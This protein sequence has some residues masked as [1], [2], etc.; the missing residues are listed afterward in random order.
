MLSED[1]EKSS[2]SNNLNGGVANHN[3]NNIQVNYGMF[4]SDRQLN[5]FVRR[6][7]WSP[8]GSF[9]LLPAAIY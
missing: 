9:F 2:F 7:D 6:P 3:N 8:D 5:T 1:D 4:L